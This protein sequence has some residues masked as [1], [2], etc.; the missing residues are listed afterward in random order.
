MLQH[1]VGA[2]YRQGD[3]S[4]PVRPAHLQAELNLRCSRPVQRILGPAGSNQ[5]PHVL[6]DGVCKL[7]PVP[8]QDLDAHKDRKVETEYAAAPSTCSSASTHGKAKWRVESLEE[9]NLA[10]AHQSNSAS[11]KLLCQGLMILSTKTA[12]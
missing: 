2:I 4:A 11:E 9:C 3:S 7:G 6:R 12:F 5:R 10:T 8:L 1:P